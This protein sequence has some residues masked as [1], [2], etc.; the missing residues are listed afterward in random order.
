VIAYAAAILWIVAR[1][2][3]MDRKERWILAVVLLGCAVLLLFAAAAGG[4]VFH[5][6]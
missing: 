2:R 1:H 5:T 6:R 4:A 3:K